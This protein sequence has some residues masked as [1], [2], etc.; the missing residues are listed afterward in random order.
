MKKKKLVN[1]I[2]KNRSRT[3]FLDTV[4]DFF[5]GARPIDTGDKDSSTF[6][7]VKTG[8]KDIYRQRKNQGGSPSQ[9]ILLGVEEDDIVNRIKF[10]RR[11]S[12]KKG[13]LSFGS[14]DE[15]IENFIMRRLSETNGSIYTTEVE[16][17]YPD[18]GQR[19][20]TYQNLEIN[21][22]IKI[23]KK[24]TGR[25][26]VSTPDKLIQYL[27]S[28]KNSL[29][30]KLKKVDDNIKILWNDFTDSLI[31]SSELS[32]SLSVK[33]FRDKNK[34]VIKKLPKLLKN[35]LGRVLEKFE[36]A[37]KDIFTQAGKTN[38]EIEKSGKG[39]KASSFKLIDKDSPIFNLDNV[40][41][42]DISWLEFINV[43]KK[44]VKK[45]YV[46]SK[47]IYDEWNLDFVNEISE[48]PT[49]Y[50]VTIP[51][52]GPYI[53]SLTS[54]QRLTL[55]VQLKK[56]ILTFFLQSQTIPLSSIVSKIKEEYKE[57]IKPDLIENE[58]IVPILQ[59]L[60][61]VIVKKDDNWTLTIGQLIEGLIK[62]TNNYT[63]PRKWRTLFGDIIIYVKRSPRKKRYE[64]EI[65][66]EFRERIL[67]YFGYI[68]KS[69]KEQ[70]ELSTRIITWL[71]GEKFKGVLTKYKEDGKILWGLSKGDLDLSEKA[72]EALF[73][74]DASAVE[75]IFVESIIASIAID[76]EKVKEL[77]KKYNNERE[78]LVTQLENTKQSCKALEFSIKNQEE[79]FKKLQDT[80]IE[81]I[82]ES[83][84]S[85]LNLWKKVLG[86]KTIAKIID[87]T[88]TLSRYL[89]LVN[90]ILALDPNENDAIKMATYFSTRE[91]FNALQ[92]VKSEK[93]AIDFQ[94]ASL[95]DYGRDWKIY[96][97]N[98]QQI[99]Q[100]LFSDDKTIIERAMFRISAQLEKERPPIVFGME[101][102]ISQHTKKLETYSKLIKRAQQMMKE[103][104]IT[105]DEKRN[106]ENYIEK[107][108]KQARGLEEL[109]PDDNFE[110][111][112]LDLT[113]NER[114]ERL[115]AQK[116]AQVES[117][118]VGTLLKNVEES[119]IEREI[120]QN[121]A[122]K[123]QA[124]TNKAER[125]RQIA[126]LSLEESERQQDELAMEVA[127]ATRAKLDA[128]EKAEEDSTS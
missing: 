52:S 5:S 24:I 124:E 120:A 67:R 126:Q 105:Y 104:G 110:Q 13:N 16:K 58:I 76:G 72:R 47:R 41:N 88:N 4:S 71:V 82:S 83:I 33:D 90:E 51:D 21:D 69:K 119:N 53:D 23:S 123:A 14:T 34:S 66:N 117:N 75:K 19:N 39:N 87:Y 68:P 20:T 114:N 25:M 1:E 118:K 28:N 59:N 46:F 35:N 95:K 15:D 96:Q 127:K 8:T 100:S 2:I 9:E 36:E 109:A 98:V 22:F 111:R 89:R 70:I 116:K 108:R 86:P 49:D 92:Y 122:I 29:G 61:S 48:R 78:R 80:N 55:D 79:M 77:N 73:K 125:D 115:E 128:T 85:N 3:G 84:R 6:Q 65:V 30:Q 63:P 10:G 54:S 42:V 50:N 45:E 43:V 27:I 107:V 74:N 37:L 62:I 17:K 57:I 113:R 31:S 60:G 44:N 103:P 7:R 56:D 11:R 40:D 101:K 102:K 94:I 32:E 93:A 106:L 12:F 112:L 91:E 64:E 26:I 38:L 121:R 99:L 97:D 81:K 18:E